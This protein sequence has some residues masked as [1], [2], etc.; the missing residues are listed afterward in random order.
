MS[1]IEHLKSLHMKRKRAVGINAQG[2]TVEELKKQGGLMSA[3]NAMAFL[4]PEAEVNMRHLN[5]TFAKE[6]K[7][8]DQ[9]RAMKDFIDKEVARRKGYLEDYEKRKEE[10]DIANLRALQDRKLYVLED[11]YEAIPRTYAPQNQ[12]EI[13]YAILEGIPEISLGT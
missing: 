10:A 5:S 8:T 7:R 9:E 3:D 13:G 11:K 12:G 2:L 6:T 4:D 1:K